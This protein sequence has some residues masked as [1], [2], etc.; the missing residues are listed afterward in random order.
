MTDLLSRNGKLSPHK[1][2][3]ITNMNELFSNFMLQISEKCQPILQQI[4]YAI[5]S[6]GV[7]LLIAKSEASNGHVT[8]CYPYRNAIGETKGDIFRK[9]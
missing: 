3:K 9:S 5:A 1:C 2:G 7:L 8:E 4:C 6:S